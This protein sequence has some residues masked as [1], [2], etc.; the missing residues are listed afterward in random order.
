MNKIKLS[1]FV[2][3]SLLIA[4]AVTACNKG[5][6]NN[7]SGKKTIAVIPKGVSHFFWQSVK[8]GADAAG[9]DMNV[10]IIWKGPALE[11]DISGQINIVE[12]MINRRVDGIVLAPSHG[13]SLVPIA[14]RAQKAGIPLTIFDSGIGTQN[15]VSYVATD[16][17]QGGVVAARR[18]GEKLGGKGK[19]A[20]LGV[21]KG[22]V[23]TDEREEGFRE[24]ILKEFPGINLIPVIFYGESVATKSLSVAEDILTANPDLAGIFASNET[25]TVGSVNAI[26]Q[27]NLAGKVILVG[28]DASPDL[29]RAIKEGGIDSLVL[30]DPFKMGYE[31]VKTIMDKLAGKTPERRIDTGVKLITKENMD[32][33][34]MQRLIK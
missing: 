29:V 32:T 23:S 5:A 31:G 26:R 34:E 21:K 13:D 3:L 27:R 2:A 7:A 20:I 22:S 8:A 11:T 24:T 10:D 25:S 18:M 6:G 30:Q 12:D 17:R 9:K 4:V 19:V 28:F 33:P 15:Y 14:E 1:I 16:N